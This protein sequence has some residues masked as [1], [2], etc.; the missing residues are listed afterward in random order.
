MLALLLYEKVQWGVEVWGHSENL[1]KKNSSK[2]ANL[3]IYLHSHL[4][5]Q[6]TLLSQAIHRE[7][8][9]LL[10][11]I[12]ARPLFFYFCLSSIHRRDGF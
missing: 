1:A 4:I 12:K 7:F 5:I 3:N 6:Q 2:K 9:D 10:V 8:R 11:S